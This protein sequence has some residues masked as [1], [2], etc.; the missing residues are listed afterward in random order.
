[1][2]YVYLLCEMNDGG[3]HLSSNAQPT[4]TTNERPAFRRAYWTA[5]RLVSKSIL[6]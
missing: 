3:N 5:I 6:F 1:M 2:P 4:G